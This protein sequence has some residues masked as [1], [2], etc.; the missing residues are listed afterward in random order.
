MTFENKIFLAVPLSWRQ[1]PFSN[2]LTSIVVFLKQI[3]DF[4]LNRT[5]ALTLSVGVALKGL[6]CSH[7]VAATVYWTNSKRFGKYEPFTR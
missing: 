3:S 7:E 1:T 6:H 4:S 5:C 2:L